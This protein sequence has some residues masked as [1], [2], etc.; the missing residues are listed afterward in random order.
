MTLDIHGLM[1][2]LAAKRPVFHSE[3][4]FQFALAW[5]IREA[6]G[7]DVRLEFRPSAAKRM[8]LDIWVPEIGT[9]LELKY[10]TRKL[11]MKCG[12]D[13]FALLNQGARDLG[14]YHFLR[15]VER[16]EHMPEDLPCANG[17]IAVLLTNDRSY[18]LPSREATIDTDFHI[19]EG[20]QL[21]PKVELSWAPGAKTGEG[22]PPIVL[23]RPYRLKWRYYGRP[24]DE[25]ASP[26]NRQF[27]YL[28][29]EVSRNHA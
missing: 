28:A 15:D 11:D 20:R 5:Q 2:G 26:P 21:P 16:L 27:R 4:D 25:S 6:K 7:L 18:W 9:P 12:G 22:K 14:R 24:I 3:A 29:V 19:H 8:Y 17:G 10:R 13:A 1:G 23:R